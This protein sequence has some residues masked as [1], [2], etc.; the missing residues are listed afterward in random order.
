MDEKAGVER[1]NSKKG[2]K[3]DEHMPAAWR[4]FSSFRIL[5]PV[6]FSSWQARLGKFKARLSSDRSESDKQKSRTRSWG[7]LAQLTTSCRAGWLGRRG[8]GGAPIAAAERLCAG[9][10]H[11]V[12]S[13]Q[14]F[15]RQL[16]SRTNRG[17]ILNINI[18]LPL[19]WRN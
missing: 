19:F 14:C 4:E 2:F 11:A 6:R 8:T 18:R 1:K 12:R 13:L 17:L 3:K 10:L 7:S 5:L 16:R 15:L 9:H